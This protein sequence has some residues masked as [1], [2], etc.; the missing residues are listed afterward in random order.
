MTDDIKRLMDEV[1]TLK[2]AAQE[3]LTALRDGVAYNGV[4]AWVKQEARAGERWAY[5]E[6]ERRIL[7]ALNALAALVE[8]D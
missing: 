3:A 5:R 1:A 7:N 6:P 2:A 4:D 8:E